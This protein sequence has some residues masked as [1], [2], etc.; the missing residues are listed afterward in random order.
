ME[1]LM[2]NYSTSRANHPYEKIEYHFSI[3]TASEI[4]DYCRQF[5]KILNDQPIF[6]GSGFI[7]KNIKVISFKNNQ[8]ARLC[9]LFN[10]LA[11]NVQSHKKTWPIHSFGNPDEFFLFDSNH[12]LTPQGLTLWPFGTPRCSLDVLSESYKEAL[13]KLTTGW[14]QITDKNQYYTFIKENPFK[15]EELLIRLIASKLSLGISVQCKIDTIENRLYL[16]IEKSAFEV[17][18]DKFGFKF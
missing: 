10:N 4:V 18:V 5:A 3:E 17:A 2:N 6:N 1:S 7:V 16:W 11:T 8:D 14:K 12:E 13:S 9:G 15:E